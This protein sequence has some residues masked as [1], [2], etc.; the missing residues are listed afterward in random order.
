MVQLYD[1]DQSGTV[2]AAEIQAAIAAS[3]FLYGKRGALLMASRLT[4][5]DV[6]GVVSEVDQ[7]ART[8]VA[9]PPLA[10]SLLGALALAG[11]GVMLIPLFPAV[12]ADANAVLDFEEFIQLMAE[13]F[14]VS[15]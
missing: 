5:D 12:V 14:S 2:S 1:V 9:P 8:P 3:T 13:A 7:G 4:T 15:K 10:H 11:V 6:E